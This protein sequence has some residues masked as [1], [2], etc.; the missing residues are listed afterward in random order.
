MK[1]YYT[2]RKR[3]I[4]AL[5]NIEIIVTILCIMAT[6]LCFIY[7]HVR[8]S[9]SNI[10]DLVLIF[11]LFWLG[12]TPIIISIAVKKYRIG[13]LGIPWLIISFIGSIVTIELKFVE[14]NIFSIIAT[15]LLI[16][17]FIS[18]LIF[19]VI[20]KNKKL[21]ALEN[22][23]KEKLLALENER[24]KRSYLSLIEECFFECENSD[25]LCDL[26]TKLLT[27]K[28]S[29][30]LCES[31]P[32]NDNEKELMETYSKKLSNNKQIYI[33]ET[34]MRHYKIIVDSIQKKQLQLVA[35]IYK[36]T[37]AFKDCIN[38]YS[39][40]F[41]ENNKKLSIEILEKS[42][43]IID[44]TRKRMDA[45]YTANNCNIDK[46]KGQD[47]EKYCA[48]LLIAYG[49]TNVEVTKGSGDQGVDIVGNYGNIKYAIQCKRYSHKLGNSPIQEVVAGKNYY[50][51]QMA[52]VI[53]N[54]F[55]TESAV[56]LAKA[57]NVVLCDRDKLMK[58]IYFTDNQWGNL[59]ENLKIV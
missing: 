35:K 17:I 55:F 10:D 39:V 41:D 16:S 53:T 42:D 52:L 23:R 54:N 58:L 32:L 3:R 7:N 6:I 40:H 25:F 21:L 19:S 1:N 27:L 36:A 4:N 11:I 43:L 30:T 47:F 49:F 9:I 31:L 8:I 20:F 28:K 24:K 13:A 37:Q 18:F 12:V 5:F 38:T 26:M 48:N 14:F 34:L 51:C 50:K 59:L 33:R 15:S 56:E 46:M 2:K 45:Y 57:N 44:F 29:V 22:E